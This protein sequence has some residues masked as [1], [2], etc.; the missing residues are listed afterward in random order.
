MSPKKQL[1]T[2]ECKDIALSMTHNFIV[3]I[4]RLGHKAR[5]GWVWFGNVLKN[6]QTHKLHFEG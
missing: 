4:F 3:V 2:E 6:V 1:H 5:F